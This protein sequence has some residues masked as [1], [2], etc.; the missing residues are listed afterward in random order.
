[1]MASLIMA[2]G[3][4]AARSIAAWVFRDIDFE[5]ADSFFIMADYFS[6]TLTQPG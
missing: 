6:L 5:R 4:M 3:A 2:A 1:M